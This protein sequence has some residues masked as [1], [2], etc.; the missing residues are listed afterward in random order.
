MKNHLLLCLLLIFGLTCH[1]Q[2]LS[3][4]LN[5]PS[6]SKAALQFS[7]DAAKNK[8]TGDYGYPTK[9]LLGLNIGLEF[10][11]R[12]S[13]GGK[14]ASA[15]DGYLPEPADDPNASGFY[16]QAGLE[17]IGKGTEFTGFSGKT[18]LTYLE[19]PIYGLYQY[20]VG[21][22]GCA[23]A[24]LGPYVA[25]GLGG[26]D[27]KE[28]SFG[29]GASDGGYRRPDAGVTFTLGYELNMGLTVRLAYDLGLVNTDYPPTAPGYNRSLSL[30]VSYE[31]L[32]LFSGK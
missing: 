18:R 10:A 23:I 11:L 15:K 17:V 29:D 27:D 1:A 5:L 22:N 2:D 26:K 16:I 6:E 3:N 20:E 14:G 21:D 4:L 12:M 7:A 28:P 32:R 8:Q 19:L 24:G 30:K 9:E 13:G 31:F 25:Y